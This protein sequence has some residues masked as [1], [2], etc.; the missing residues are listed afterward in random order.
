ML[1][2][3]TVKV[4]AFNVVKSPP[5]LISVQVELLVDCCHL[6]DVCPVIE[7]ENVT[8]PSPQKVWLTGAVL[9]VGPHVKFNGC[10]ALKPVPKS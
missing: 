2:L 4:V 8:E 9:T 7:A 3:A 10:E 1:R 6:K 5:A